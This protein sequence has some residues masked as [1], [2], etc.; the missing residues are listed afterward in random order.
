LKTTT[1]KIQIKSWLGK[2]LFEYESENNTIAETLRN[3][4]LRGADLRNAILSGADLRGADLRGAVLRGA[5]LRNADLRNAD[6]RNADLSD[7][8]LR[9]A[10]LRGA[11][12]RN[13]ILSGADLSGA[14]LRG[15]DLPIYCKWAVSILDDKIKIGCKIK[16]IEDWDLWFSGTETFSTKRDSEDFLRI[17][18][19]Y[20]A[21]KVYY[22]IV[23]NKT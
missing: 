23:N 16:S 15:A 2:L 4:V 10:D 22:Q 8:D 7:A 19:N 1:I 13:A 20:E 6:L 5:D 21:V 3:A 18:A 9:G 12:L 11:D 17:R 14:D